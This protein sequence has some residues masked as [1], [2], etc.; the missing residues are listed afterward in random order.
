ME[1]KGKMDRPCKVLREPQRTSLE[2]WESSGSSLHRRYMK[3][4]DEEREED[5][6]GWKC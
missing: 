3:G 5:E 1:T 2:D 6:G 4:D